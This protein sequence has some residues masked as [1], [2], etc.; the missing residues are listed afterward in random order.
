[1]KTYILILLLSI[2]YDVGQ[3]KE[4]SKNFVN[5]KPFRDLL[6]NVGTANLNAKDVYFVT[7]WIF[8]GSQNKQQL[9]RYTVLT[10]SF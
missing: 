6:T 3:C 5:I 8:Y 2:N 1:M 9:C 7:K 4:N 10:I